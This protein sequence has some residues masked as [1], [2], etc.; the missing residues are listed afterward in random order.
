MK[1]KEFKE[2]KT[3]KESE[4]TKMIFD[5][6]I[7]LTKFVGRVNTNKEKNLKKGKMLRRSIAQIMTVLNMKG[8]E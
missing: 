2:L 8:K 3:K 6:K 7:E 1:T 5:M 4:L